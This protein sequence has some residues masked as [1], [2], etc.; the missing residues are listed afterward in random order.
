L[1]RKP[2]DRE[3]IAVLKMTFGDI[4]TGEGAGSIA[5][6]Q[7]TARMAGDGASIP[8]FD[9]LFASKSDPPLGLY[10]AGC[11]AKSGEG[12]HEGDDV[13]QG[14]HAR[15]N[16]VKGISAS[17]QHFAASFRCEGGAEAVMPPV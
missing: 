14:D 4:G 17:V 13:V 3:V 5:Q 8:S 2:S 11:G 15:D 10:P 6:L 16:R 9:L 7:T 12:G 1:Q